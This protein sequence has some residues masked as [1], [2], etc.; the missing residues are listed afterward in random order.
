MPIDGINY[1][2]RHLMPNY[3]RELSHAGVTECFESVFEGVPTVS[4]RYTEDNTGLQ[5][6]WPEKKKEKKESAAPNTPTKF[7][8]R[9]DV[10]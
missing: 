9:A 1:Y 4:S 8:K 5:I 2:I 3:Q 7:E 10:I 6:C